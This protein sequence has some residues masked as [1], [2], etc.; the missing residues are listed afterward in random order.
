MRLWRKAF[1]DVESWSFREAYQNYLEYF[2][3]LMLEKGGEL[4]LYRSCEKLRS[5]K[6]RKE[7]KKF[8][9]SIKEQRLTRWVTSCVGTAC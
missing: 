5:I 7:E 3:N 6:H 8:S 1:Y 4:Q 9:K 2:L